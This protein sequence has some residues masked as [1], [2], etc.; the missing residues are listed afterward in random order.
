MRPNDIKRVLN[1]YFN[2]NPEIQIAYL[3]GSLAKGEDHPESDVDLAILLNET[4]SPSQTSYRYKAELISELM[5]F[6]K[7]KRIDLSILNE[8]PLL[9]CFNVVHDGILLHSKNEIMRIQF[10]A[11]TMS[12]YFDQ[13]Y[14]Y[15]RHAELALERIAR[16]GF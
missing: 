8:S 14:Y 4:S 5:S 9:L 16:G 1:P 6:L 10:E 2:A 7:T 11:R 3:F 12:F 13:E 15:R